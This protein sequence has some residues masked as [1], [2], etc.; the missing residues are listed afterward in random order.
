MPSWMPE[1][2]DWGMRFAR[3]RRPVR[4]RKR[5]DRETRK[6]DA[7]GEGGMAEGEESTAAAIAF[8]G[9]MGRGIPKRKPVRVLKVPETTRVAGR[10]MVP[11]RESA[12]VRGRK[13]P[14]SPRAPE[15]SERGE[16]KRTWRL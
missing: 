9:W 2:N 1:I 16:V 14:R 11:W 5:R 12:R 13:V 8:M 7:V 3:E 4:E 10:E 15:I 6:P